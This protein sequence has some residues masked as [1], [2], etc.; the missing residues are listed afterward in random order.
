MNIIILRKKIYI[1]EPI[2]RSKKIINESNYING[3][4]YIFEPT[5]ESKKINP[6]Y[7]VQLIED[8]KN[9]LEISNAR[10]KYLDKKSRNVN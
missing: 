7:M 5:K 2:T 4:K 3:K 6:G 9:E 1:F 8:N 10:L